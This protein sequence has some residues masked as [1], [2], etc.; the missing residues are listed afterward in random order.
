MI[1]NFSRPPFRKKPA[2]AHA[3]NP[4]AKPHHRA[5]IMLHQKDCEAARSE[6]FHQSHHLLGFFRVHP[7]KGFIQKDDVQAGDEGLRAALA[8]ARTE[9]QSQRRQRS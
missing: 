4:V 9:E 6:P 2:E 3:R 8:S 5:H 7:R 1:A